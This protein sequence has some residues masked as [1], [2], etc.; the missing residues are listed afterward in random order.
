M[1]ASCLGQCWPDPPPRMAEI[2]GLL[3]QRLEDGLVPRRQDKPKPDRRDVDLFAADHEVIV[4]DGNII[5][6][7]GQR[8]PDAAVDRTTVPVDV[9]D[10]P[11][12]GHSRSTAVRCRGG[13]GCFPNHRNLKQDSGLGAMGECK[14]LTDRVRIGQEWVHLRQPGGPRDSRTR[15]CFDFQL[16]SPRLVR[17]HRAASMHSGSVQSIKLP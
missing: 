15:G 14:G 16:S 10:T 6:P 5:R 3:Y 13:D 17:C 11:V 1:T 2:R 4:A 7:P 8:G 12:N 9:R